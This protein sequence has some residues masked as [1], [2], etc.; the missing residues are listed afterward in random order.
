MWEVDELERLTDRLF[1]QRL[2]GRRRLVDRAASGALSLVKMLRPNFEG[3]AL[4]YA[5]SRRL[6]AGN[7]FLRYD[8]SSRRIRKAV[9]RDGI[10]AA[11]FD[12]GRFLYV[13][14]S[15]TCTDGEPDDGASPS[16]CLLR[17]TAPIRFR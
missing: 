9:S 3:G 2:G 7:R 1:L 12:A 8:L 13:L 14:R 17:R 11:A 4:V 6:A 15:S 16:P 10:V 5:I